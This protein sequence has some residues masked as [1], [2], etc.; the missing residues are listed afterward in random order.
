[1][2]QVKLAKRSEHKP[3]G[4]SSTSATKKSHSEKGCVSTAAPERNREQVEIRQTG[5]PL[6]RE[7]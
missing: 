1:M 6:L 3:I 5:L 7:R 4:N 2:E